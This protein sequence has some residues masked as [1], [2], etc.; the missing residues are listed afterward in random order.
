MAQT[1]SRLSKDRLDVVDV[2]EGCPTTRPKMS[3]PT[4]PKTSSKTKK[5]KNLASIRDVIADS[6]TERR[7]SNEDHINKHIVNAVWNVTYRN[8]GVM[9]VLLEKEKAYLRLNVY[10]PWKVLRAMDRRDEVLNME[11]LEVLSAV[12]SADLKRVATILERGAQQAA[13]YPLHASRTLSGAECLNFDYGK[14]LI[15]LLVT[16]T[17]GVTE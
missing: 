5:E 16:L 4:T 9:L 2:D 8:G 17:V 12:E 14:V 6:V 10:S 13:Y 3:R 15:G 11:G 7:L 1:I